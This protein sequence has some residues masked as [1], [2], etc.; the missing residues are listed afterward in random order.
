MDCCSDGSTVSCKISKTNLTLKYL[1]AFA[2]SGTSFKFIKGKYYF[3]NKKRSCGTVSA[4]RGNSKPFIPSRS[5]QNRIL[6]IDVASTWH[7]HRVYVVRTHLLPTAELLFRYSRNR[8]ANAIKVLQLAIDARAW[9]KLYTEK[10][11]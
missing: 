2:S 4:I 11:S 8:N 1:L 7:E 10:N 9:R 6:E 3:N 5:L